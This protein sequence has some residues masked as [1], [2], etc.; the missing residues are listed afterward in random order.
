MNI[1]L[2]GASKNIGYYSA[3]RLLSKGHT[4]V[5]LLRNTS[6]FDAD[7]DIQRHV[8]EGSARLIKGDALVP[9]DVR[10]LWEVTLGV[11]V[12]IDYVLFTLGGLAS[13]IRCSNKCAA[14]ANKIFP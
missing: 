4:C 5:F 8:K 12:G 6:V 1:L 13:K 7:S 14:Y 11:G 3:L 2:I 9:E 10:R